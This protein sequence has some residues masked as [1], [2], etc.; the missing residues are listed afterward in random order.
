MRKAIGVFV[1]AIVA[2]APA[3]GLGQTSE[4]EVAIP[5][6]IPRWTSRQVYNAGVKGNV[7][8]VSMQSGFTSTFMLPGGYVINSRIS[9]RETAYRLQER[10]DRSKRLSTGLHAPLW[11]DLSVDVLL[12]DNRFFD[13]VI[14]FNGAL[15][16]VIN[17]NQ[18]AS[19]NLR[20][21]RALPQGF[22]VN[23]HSGVSMV[24][25]EQTFLTNQTR[26]GAVSGGVSYKWR[27]NVTWSGRGFL[28]KAS[29]D[30]TTGGRENSGL[31]RDEDSLAT[32]VDIQINPNT[33]MK[34]SYLRFTRTHEFMDLPRGVYIEQQFDEDLIRETQTRNVEAIQW[35]SQV[36]PFEGFVLK[37]KGVQR[38]E[39]SDF[40]VDKRR[41]N[42][43]TNTTIGANVS[44]LMG[45]KTHLGVDLQNRDIDTDQGTLS[46]ASNT[47]KNKSA[48]L[49]LVHPF[50]DTFQFTFQTGTT[51]RQIFYVDPFSNPRDLDHLNQY[52]NLRISSKPFPKIDAQISVAVTQA[53]VV[54]IDRSLSQNNRTETS[55]DLRPELTYHINDR[56]DVRQTYGLNI[57]VTEFVFMEDDDVLDRNIRFSNTV[58]AQLTKTISTELF[59][60]LL[61][62]D[63]GSFLRPAPGAERL[64]DVDQEDR[65]DQMD[66][67]FEYTINKHLMLQGKSQYSRREDQFAGST[68]KNIFRD[69]GIEVGVV[70]NYDFGQQ[71]VLKF[72]LRK[73][74][75]FGRFN[76]EAQEDYWLMDSS[77]T[78]T[79]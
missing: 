69:G 37:L 77:L 76:S 50:T 18:R 27:D 19:T 44:Y 42:E 72:S 16:D 2:L 48:K 58:R 43:R 36:S 55:Y 53:D 1:T 35:E 11:Q 46:V 64:L 26:E 67:K 45:G 73:V 60:T 40:A 24:R 56:V 68:R 28:K 13:R 34:V 31:G 29:E 79:F 70:G 66:I 71:R 33:K 51:L 10:E 17:D 9:I 52:V 41:F 22:H 12:A 6:S 61:L 47:E 57:E 39:L 74:N 54:N 23:G 49:S 5:D 7:S 14:T 75:R 65:R 3:A 38:Q 32:N 8:R 63:R 25:S 59:Y 15:Q 4:G 78:Y 30:A 20:Y 62:H 21:A